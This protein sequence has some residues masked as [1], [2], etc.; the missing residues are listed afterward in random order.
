MG[1]CLLRKTNANGR[2]D[3]ATR[4]TDQGA[5]LGTRASTNET[6]EADS[7]LGAIPL[8]HIA[9][10][11]CFSMTQPVQHNFPL[12]K[13]KHGIQSVSFQTVNRLQLETRCPNTRPKSG[14]SRRALATGLGHP[15]V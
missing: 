9:T 10:N 13:S 4:E 7:N 11:D 12:Q 3:Q 14:C 15:L 2:K 6:H 1:H 5:K 8:R